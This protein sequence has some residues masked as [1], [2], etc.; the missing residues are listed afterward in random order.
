[1]QVLIREAFAVLLVVHTAVADDTQDRAADL[2]K[3][4]LS[5]ALHRLSSSRNIPGSS[6]KTALRP[7]PCQ[8]TLSVGPMPL[9]QASTAPVP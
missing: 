8:P 9:R 4:L 1:M 5:P 3:P 7:W 2:S 6:G